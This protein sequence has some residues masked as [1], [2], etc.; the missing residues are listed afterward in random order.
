MLQY[1]YN[2]QS[3]SGQCGISYGFDFKSAKFLQ[4][5]IIYAIYICPD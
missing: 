5:L 3:L 1:W 4:K 2:F